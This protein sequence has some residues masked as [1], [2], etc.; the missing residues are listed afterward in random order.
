[1]F[2]HIHSTK[3]SPQVLLRTTHSYVNNFTKEKKTMSLFIKSLLFFVFFPSKF[4]QS[5]FDNW[6]KDFVKRLWGTFVTQNCK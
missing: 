6:L 1:M 5:I 2:Q 4:T 3:C